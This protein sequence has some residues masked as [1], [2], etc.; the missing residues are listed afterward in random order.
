MHGLWSPEAFRNVGEHNWEAHFIENAS[1]EAHIKKG[2]FVP[3][4]VHSDGA[5]VIDVRVGSKESSA[6]LSEQE[7]GWLKAASDPYLFISN[8]V[9]NVSG[10][11]YIGGQLTGAVACI[12]VP[13][14]RWQVVVHLLSWPES[15]YNKETRYPPDFIVTLNP[16]TAGVSY[17]QV[18]ETFAEEVW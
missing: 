12:R 16:E 3:I 4:Y 6:G 14:G 15:S 9:A 8:G 7:K 1:I 13:P 17:R 18:T 2:E 11:E 5:P 10:I